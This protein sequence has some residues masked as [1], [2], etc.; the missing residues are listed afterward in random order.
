MDIILKREK[1]N[2]YMG[3]FRYEFRLDSSVVFLGK[4]DHLRLT[5]QYTES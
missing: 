4:T 2:N 5:S 3:R 1:Y